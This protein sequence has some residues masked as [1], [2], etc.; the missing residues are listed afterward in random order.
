MSENRQPY[1]FGFFDSLIAEAGGVPQAALHLDVDAIC[2]AYQAVEPIARRLGVDAPKARLAGL[3]YVH[4]STLGAEVTISPDADEPY[5]KPCI[6]TLEDIDRL[7]EPDD[8]LAAELVKHRLDL[9]GRLRQRRPD[10]SDHIGH[11]FQGPITTAALLMGQD[12][13]MLPYDDPARAHR[14]IEFGVR[15]ALNYRKV[16]AT[17]QQRPTRPRS[18]GFP[19]DFAGMFPPD[20]FRRFVLPYWRM[21]F[22]G[23]GAAERHVH[24]ELLRE[25]HLPF[26][27]ELGVDIYDPSVDQYLSPEVV[28]R[29]CPVRYFLR[30][31]PSDVERLSADELVAQYRYLVS[32]KPV[33]VTFH[34]GR[35]VDEHKIAALLAVA[36]E[37]A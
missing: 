34:M 31:W 13:F 32:F 5:V 9:V 33:A 23:L 7:R 37:M 14:L 29:C 21:M 30:I 27:A 28:A 25:E 19:D 3:A 2:H 8:Y 24:S 1:Q 4:I 15:S 36:R 6:R 18:G 20:A 22:D 10:A 17:H 35:L 11:D 16:L 12:F 26:L